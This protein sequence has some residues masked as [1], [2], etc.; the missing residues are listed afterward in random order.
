MVRR[1]GRVVETPILK[2]KE[3]PFR[4]RQMESN[5]HPMALRFKVSEHWR[6]VEA[7]SKSAQ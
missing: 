2:V 7:L 6:R 4:N 1:Q 3:V 5:L